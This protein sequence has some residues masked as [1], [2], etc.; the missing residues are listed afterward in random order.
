MIRRYI[1]L[2]LNIVATVAMLTAFLPML[3]WSRLEGVPVPSHFDIHGA[4]DKVGGRE[5][6]LTLALVGLGVYIVMMLAQRYPQ[7]VN[8]R[9]L[10]RKETIADIRSGRVLRPRRRS[11]NP[12]VNSAKR[13]LAAQLNLL[14]ALLFSFCAIPFAPLGLDNAISGVSFFCMFW[15]L[16]L[17][18]YLMEQFRNR[19]IRK[20]S[21][22]NEMEAPNH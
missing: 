9:L 7:M 4:V 2:S 1:N 18:H 5:I 10:P 21:Q 16:I 17:C 20:T 11:D 13:D 22:S 8:L 12:V 6:L 19:H 15:V 14:L 3:S